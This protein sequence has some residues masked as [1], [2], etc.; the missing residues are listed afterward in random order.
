LTKTT[1]PKINEKAK[2]SYVC[3]YETEIDRQLVWSQ[4]GPYIKTVLGSDINSGDILFV[5]A[6]M[7]AI[8]EVFDM[9]LTNPGEDIDFYSSY[10]SNGIVRLSELK[11]DDLPSIWSVL[12]H[13]DSDVKIISTIEPC[14]FI[15]KVS[16]LD[17]F[18]AIL[19]GVS[20][21]PKEYTLEAFDKVH[22]NDKTLQLRN[23]LEF[24][25]TNKT[26]YD[27][28]EM[29]FTRS[30]LFYGPPGNGKTTTIKAVSK[31]LNAQASTFDFSAASQSPDSDFQNWV[32]GAPESEPDY[33]THWDD[34]GDE[35]IQYKNSGTVPLRLL[36]LED[37]DRFFPKSGPPQTN[38][39]LSAILN[40]LD[41]AFERRNVIII[42]T[43][44]NP[45]DLD[46]Q[47]LARPG[48]FDKQIFYEEPS[49]D[50]AVSYLKDQFTGEN[51]KS[52]TL[53]AAAKKFK[54][55]SYAVLREVFLTSA[56]NAFA[57][58]AD[59][60]NDEDVNLTTTSMLEQF[61]GNV[62]K[63]SKT[64]FGFSD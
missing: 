40:A 42:A 43:A 22:W 61:D 49:F 46:Q 37:V 52:K 28:R 26:F 34:E 15:I 7:R 44:N 10:K 13:K 38:V 3:R 2:I 29:P 31:Y 19:A 20:I 59:K 25:V 53:K 57:R 12:V 9:D 45:E 27:K 64:T 36:I 50:D 8:N 6:P 58:K 63:S 47:V 21:A 51:V 24:F 39:S 32:M 35:T 60:I 30:Y 56:S 4:M 11:G 41:G 17:A 23:D 55:H 16:D 48:R 14:K 54:G 62:M 18:E 1:Q 33:P 5:K